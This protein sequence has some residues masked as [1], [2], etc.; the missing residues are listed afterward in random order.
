MAKIFRPIRNACGVILDI[1]DETC[2]LD[3]QVQRMLLDGASVIE[4][5]MVNDDGNPPTRENG[6]NR[7]MLY[8]L[9]VGLQTQD[10]CW[11]NVS[12]LTV[13]SDLCVGIRSWPSNALSM[14]KR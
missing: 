2:R 8:I 11:H 14:T 9:K 13:C 12:T 5:T 6:Q 10:R 4:V 7:G 3:S 1:V